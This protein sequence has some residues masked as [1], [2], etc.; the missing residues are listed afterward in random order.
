VDE[1]GKAVLFGQYLAKSGGERAVEWQLGEMEKQTAS[2]LVVRPIQQGAPERSLLPGQDQGSAEEA[3]RVK[4]AAQMRDRPAIVAG[5]LAK[6]EQ[7]DQLTILFCAEQEHT[8]G[9]QRPQGREQIPAFKKW[10]WF[11]CALAERV[12]CG[13]GVGGLHAR[14]GRGSDRRGGQGGGRSTRLR[15]D[16]RRTQGLSGHDGVPLQRRN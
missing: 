5:V 4:P 14:P 7:A 11:N 2:T 12:P 9:V 10:I 8:V 6:R 16:R 15:I 13:P 1:R 3:I